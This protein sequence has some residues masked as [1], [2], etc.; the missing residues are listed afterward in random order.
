MGDANKKPESA[1]D[2]AQKKRKAEAEAASGSTAFK[3]TK[4]DDSAAP[5]DVSSCFIGQLSW[6]VDEAWL[7][8]E[9]EAA[10]EIVSARV[11]TERDSGRSKG[12]VLILFY[13]C[14]L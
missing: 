2:A 8:S 12:F 3:K 13:H 9:L 1:A 7:R 10:G 4:T 5:G 6:N 14:D 11:V